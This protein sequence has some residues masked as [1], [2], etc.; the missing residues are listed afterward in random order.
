MFRRLTREKIRIAWNENL[1]HLQIFSTHEISKT[2]KKYE[3]KFESE[4]PSK[5]RFENQVWKIKREK[6]NDHNDY[7]KCVNSHDKYNKIN[8][9]QF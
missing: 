6:K 3:W 5:H 4:T 8:F 1:S 9:N 7:Q 2:G